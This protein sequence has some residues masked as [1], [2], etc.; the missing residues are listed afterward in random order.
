[1]SGCE[2]EQANDTVVKLTLHANDALSQ[3]I[4]LKSQFHQTRRNEKTI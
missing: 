3:P 1:M 4:Q 2:R